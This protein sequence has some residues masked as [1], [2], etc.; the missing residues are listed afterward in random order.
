MGVGRDKKR[1]GAKKLLQRD[2]T[3]TAYV[4]FT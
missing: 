1:W 4:G 2:E 3:G